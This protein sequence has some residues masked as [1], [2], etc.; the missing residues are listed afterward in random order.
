MD[1]RKKH[2]FIYLSCLNIT[3][4]SLPSLKLNGW[5]SSNSKYRGWS[6]REKFPLWKFATNIREA[7]PWE[8]YSFSKLTPQNLDNTEV[9]TIM[10]EKIEPQME[11]FLHIIVRGLHKSDYLGSLSYS[12]APQRFVLAE[13]SDWKLQV[14]SS[15]TESCDFQH[16]LDRGTG[17]MSEINR[18]SET[19]GSWPRLP[20]W[21]QG[22]KF[23]HPFM[24]M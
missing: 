24:A 7:Y 14:L 6:C 3:Q 11:R 13:N 4:G 1:V 19:G 23:L 16:S 22:R 17:S 18:A 5:L 15:L 10:R 2:L 8:V 9:L 21:P 12:D 20:H